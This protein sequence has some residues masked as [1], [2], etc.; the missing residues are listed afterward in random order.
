M[1]ELLPCPFC[2]SSK[3]FVY[4]DEW[5]CSEVECDDCKCQGPF[6]PYEK[7]LSEEAHLDLARIAWNQR[8]VLMHEPNGHPVDNA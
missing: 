8:I 6:A 1:T 5:G 2:G 4:Q 7:G 3:L